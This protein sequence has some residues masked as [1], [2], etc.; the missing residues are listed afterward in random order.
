MESNNDAWQGN[1][2]RNERNT[3]WFFC[4]IWRFFLV[5]APKKFYWKYFPTWISTIYHLAKLFVL[6]GVLIYTKDFGELCSVKWYKIFFRNKL[7]WLSRNSRQVKSRTWAR[8]VACRKQNGASDKDC[9]KAIEA[10]IFI[11]II[12]FTHTSRFKILKS[13]AFVASEKQLAS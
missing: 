4:L 2:G 8:L 11:S 12:S 5:K 6:H 9:L 7:I 13:V 1:K 10:R 3:V